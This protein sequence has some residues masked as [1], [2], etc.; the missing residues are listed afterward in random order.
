MAV[1]SKTRKKYNGYLSSSYSPGRAVVSAGNRLSDISGRLPIYSDSYGDRLRNLYQSIKDSAQFDYYAENDV[2]YRAFAD[3]YNAL[4][5][6]MGA[7]NA[8]IADSLTGGFGSTYAA[9]VSNQGTARIAEE[10]KRAI[11]EFERL[12]FE[13]KTVNDDILKEMYNAASKLR[14]DELSEYSKLSDVYLSQL[15]AAQRKYADERDF[16]YKKFGDNRDFWA[17]QFENEQSNSNRQKELTL[18]SYDV[19]K[20]LAQNKCDEFN[21]KQDNRGMRAYLDSLVKDGKI[22]QY[23]ADILYNRNKY[24]APKRSSGGGYSTRRSRSSSKSKKK[25]STQKKFKKLEDFVPDENVLKYINMRN[26]AEDYTTALNLIDLLVDEGKISKED[27]MY[28]VYYYR[29]KLVK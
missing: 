25:N 19:Y 17:T 11:P 2:A 26:R 13:A 1:S 4:A 22:T 23:M 9:D 24:V 16:A 29:D 20:K 10:V 21:E 28:Y 27:K 15:D 3:E 14:S 6:L 8:A 12:A 18:K 7:G 5:Q